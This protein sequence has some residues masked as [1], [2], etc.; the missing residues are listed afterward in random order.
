MEIVY[1]VRAVV[2][3]WWLILSATIAALVVAY[4]V[5]QSID[6]NFK[7][8]A[9]LS[10]GYTTNDINLTDDKTN[11]RDLEIKF[12]NLI[13]N[14]KSNTTLHLLSYRLML[15]DIN[16]STPFKQPPLEVRQYS[17]AEKHQ[18]G[19]LIES[20]LD[21]FA[22]L[23]KFNASDRAIIELLETYEYSPEAINKQLK[24]WRIN[25]TD[26]INIE[27]VSEN[28][29]LSAY[30]VNTF[31]DEFI[32]YNRNIKYKGSIKSIT[33]FEDLLREKKTE[34]DILQSQLNTIKSQSQIFDYKTHGQ[35]KINQ[36]EVMELSR[37]EEMR[38]INALRLSINDVQNRLSSL[39]NGSNNNSPNNSDLIELKK[40]LN[41]LNERYIS[42]G[43]SNKAL[44]DSI[45]NLRQQHDIELSRAQTSGN[46]QNT[47]NTIDELTNKL[48]DLETQLKIAQANLQTI[49]NNI[50]SLRSNTSNLSTSV[51]EV[52]EIERDIELKTQE[53]LNIQAKLNDSRNEALISGNTLKQ[54]LQGQPAEE[55]EAS[56]KL[57]IILFAG[58][59]AFS[60][61]TGLI[62]ILELF[63]LS[64]KTPEKFSQVAKLNLLGHLNKISV[65]NY[66]VSNIFNG[67]KKPNQHNEFFLQ[68]LRKI[69]F[70]LEKS[71]KRIL[72][73]TSTDKG[74]GKTLFLLSLAYSFSL[75]NKKILIID[76]NFKN[77]TL[78]KLFLKKEN[79]VVTKS[80]PNNGV[81]LLNMVNSD[82]EHERIN[83]QA[84]PYEQFIMKT[85]HNDIDMIGN[86]MGMNSPDEIFSGKRFDRF[87]QEF[88]QHYDYILLEGPALNHFSDTKE[89]VDYCEGVIGVFSS[90]KILNNL[91]KESVQSLKNL[92][93]KY[94]G[95]VL[96]KLQIKN[97][98]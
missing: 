61:T 30:A 81:K 1:L 78:T 89:L 79:V 33:F 44:L 53:Y 87:L 83:E 55:P 49:N 59:A 97:I 82:H 86:K 80:T 23:S 35:A 4:F 94:L 3:K 32:R 27:Y 47:L 18:L 48:Y 60:F 77:N 67:E 98:V 8:T 84:F 37:G 29:Y 42:G 76:T 64:I 51:T 16:N 41:I 11:P 95:S 72:L 58:I 17:T 69:R 12:N 91:D 93:G 22:V 52:S 50:V 63:D 74:E 20:K 85:A 71:G 34:L 19:K 5:A 24:V 36:L 46:K 28:P 6:P 73:I 88:S 57:L 14:M 96:N 62:I 31:C 39:K 66:E 15:H 43:S 92:D 56:K 2:R 7:S 90:D 68:S 75:I 45:I 40:K 13:Q 38:N 65:N 9:Q 25:F 21:S 10:T 26:Y 54:V 70:D